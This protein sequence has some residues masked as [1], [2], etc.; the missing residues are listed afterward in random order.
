MKFT[1]NSLFHSVHCSSMFRSVK[2][3]S[4]HPRPL[5]NPDCSFRRRSS[6]AWVMHCI[7]TLQKILLGTDKRVI[8]RQLLQSLRDPF[9]GILIITLLWYLDYHTPMSAPLLALTSRRDL[10]HFPLINRW[11]IWFL[12]L[13]FGEHHVIL[14][15]SRCGKRV[16]PITRLL[17]VQ[18]STSLSPFHWW[19]HSRVFPSLC[20]CL[21]YRHQLWHL[22]PPW[23]WLYNS[24]ILI[25]L[26]SNNFSCIL[27]NLVFT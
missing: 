9:F 15:I 18:N 26:I 8:P 20:H 5:R 21:S 1:Y 27:I 11:S 4:V 10:R 12:S 19:C 2:I 6:T 17:V 7:M 23:W 14:W 13:P 24:Y 3:L 22:D 25:D 16:P